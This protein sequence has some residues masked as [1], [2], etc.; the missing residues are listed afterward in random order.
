MPSDRLLRILTRL[1]AHGDDDAA[2][3]RLCVVSAEITA[4]SGAGIMLMLDD[5]PQGSV[6]TTDEASAVIEDLQFTLGEGPCVDAYH[7]HHPVA[8]PD[9]AD[10]AISRW[11]AF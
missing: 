2:T 5:S 11:A 10:P 7:Q 9:L 3:T 6:C 1:F 4:M 8:E